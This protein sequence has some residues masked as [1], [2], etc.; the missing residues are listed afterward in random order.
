MG[1]AGRVV[2][3][4]AVTVLLVALFALI[5]P[6]PAAAH[7]A[8][9]SG[10]PTNYRA[11]VTAIRPAVPTVAVAVGIGGQWVRVATQG[12]GQIIVLGYRGEPF[13][14]LS[15][16][17]VQINEL[18]STAAEIG[19]VRGG[20]DIPATPD[21]PAGIPAAEP[22]WV[23]KRDSDQVTWTDARLATPPQPA[24][25]SGTWELPLIVDGQQVTVLG[26][27]DWVPSPPPWPWVAALGLLTAAIAALGWVRNWHRPMAGVVVIGVLAFVL[28]LLG[29]GLAPHQSGPVIAWAGIG[30]IA[31]F[32]LVIGAVTVVSAV[33]RRQ[34]A[35]DRVVMTGIMVLLLAATD[36]SGLW[37]SQL[38]FAGPAA[39][40]RSLIVLT[41]AT[42]L[43]LLV[44][45]ARLARRTP[46]DDPPPD[47]PPSGTLPSGTSPPDGPVPDPRGSGAAS[48]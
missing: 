24:G 45:G 5:N 27:M 40:D 43:G 12:A 18:S 17:R 11:A 22:R 2:R 30:A 1:G 42:A 14:R 4:A 37:N 46:P 33:R 36:F 32:T 10:S 6:V 26:T 31:A 35:T 16:H 7:I 29:T 48:A 21:I 41:Y 13:L 15:E 23:T 47:T 44:A 34:S 38:P 8:G 3:S 39:L 20:P 28:H 9:N 19:L 25:A